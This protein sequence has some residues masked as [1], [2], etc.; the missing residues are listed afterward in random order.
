MRVKRW[1]QICIE[2]F[3]GQIL[4]IES[5]EYPIQA[6]DKQILELRDMRM[7]WWW[8]MGDYH[9]WA[10]TNG[11]HVMRVEVFTKRYDSW[12]DKLWKKITHPKG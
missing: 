1:K 4:A 10:R 11:R 3:D 8:A 9:G 2:T 12:Y 7:N 5:S 6:S